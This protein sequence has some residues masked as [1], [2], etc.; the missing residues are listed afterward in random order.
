M[1]QDKIYT[2]TKS[3]WDNDQD[4]NPAESGQGVDT[5][6]FTVPDGK[7]YVRYSVNVLTATMFSGYLIEAAPRVG[8]TGSQ[9]VTV[10][11]WYNPFGKIR[12][13]LNV[14]AGDVEVIKIYFGENN[15][16]GKAQNAIQQGQNFQII[17]RGP[18]AKELFGQITRV[19]GRPMASNFFVEPVSDTVAITLIIV[20]GLMSMGAFATIAAI[21]LYSIH[22]GYNAKASHKVHG[23]L[24]FDDELIIELTKA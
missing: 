2:R 1:A 22:E 16:V 24:P 14:L 15:W 4:W 18:D 8:A 7:K 13:T 20:L 9:K 12:Y 5:H 23:P 10:K 3:H 21:L 6:N 17:V 11:W 19:S